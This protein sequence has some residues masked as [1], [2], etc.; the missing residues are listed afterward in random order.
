MLTVTPYYN[1]DD[2]TASYCQSSLYGVTVCIAE[3]SVIISFQVVPVAGR[4]VGDEAS[5]DLGYVGEGGGAAAAAAVDGVTRL[6]AG[7]SSTADDSETHH[8]Y[9]HT[10]TSNVSGF[11]ISL[12]ILT[13]GPAVVELTPL[14]QVPGREATG[15]PIFQSLV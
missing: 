1:L 15:V 9:H 7:T 12:S 2:I 13:P 5:R 10:H 6:A 14:R 4:C 3:A 8:L 11:A